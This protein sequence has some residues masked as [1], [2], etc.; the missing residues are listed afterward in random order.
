MILDWAN[1]NLEKGPIE[2]R[3]SDLYLLSLLFGGSDSSI[4]S[5][6]PVGFRSNKDELEGSSGVHGF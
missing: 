2:S 1:K 3:N 4:K 5:R 6:N